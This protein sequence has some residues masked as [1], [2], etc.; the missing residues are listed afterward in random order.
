[1][2]FF[3]KVGYGVAGETQN[4]VWVD[5]IKEVS[6]Y[7]DVQRNT[8]RLTTDADLNSEIIVNNTI[9]IVADPYALNHFHAIKYV[10]W[11]G[12]LHTVTNVQVQ[13]PR[14]LLELGGVY[15][16]PAEATNPVGRDT[17]Q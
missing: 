14:L 2:K 1:M 15:N 10:E 5:Q 4:G 3:G 6:Y 12:A 9:S 17:G 11:A 8:R 13:S 16:G 7:G